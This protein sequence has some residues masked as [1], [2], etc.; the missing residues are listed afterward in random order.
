MPLQQRIGA[1]SVLD[2]F[3]ESAQRHSQRTALTMVMT[4]QD[5]EQPR[6]VNYRE[7]LGLIRRSANL[8]HSLAGPRP[9]VAY[10]LPSLIETHVTLWGAQ[11]AGF[12]V[13]INYLLQVQHIADLIRVSG[14]SVLVALGPHPQLAIWDKAL[15]IKA[16]LPHLQLVCVAP[17]STPAT[18]AALD[19]HTLLMQQADDHLVFGEAGRDDDVAAYFHTGGTT[20]VPKLVEHS[21]R[22]QIAAAFGGTALLHSNE[23]H[24]SFNGNP[25]FHV[26]GIILGSLSPFMAGAEVVVL[27][28]LGF[29]NPVIVR[30]YWKLVQKYRATRIGGV[31]TAIGALCDVAVD[32]ADLSS[33]QLGVCGAASIPMSVVQRFE[34]HTGHPLHEALGMTETAGL[35]CVDPAFGDRVLGSVGFRLP[36]TQVVIRRLNPDGSLGGVCAPEEIGVLTVA[37]PTVSRGYLDPEQSKG[38]FVDGLLNT[39]DLAYASADGRIHIA[40]RTKDLIIRSGHN[41]D[42]LM[43]EEAMSKHPAVTMAAAVSQP[44]VYAGELPVCYLSL[45][46]PGAA[47]QAQLHDWA[48]HH[49][50]ERPAWPK[51]FYLVPSIPVTAVGKI[52]KPQLRAD[53][54][55]RLVLRIVEESLGLNQL[56]VAAHE[57][58]KRGMTV[59]VTLARTQANLAAKIEQA[60]ASYLFESVVVVE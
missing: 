18:D 38:V 53:A 6:R 9:G 31:P 55:E 51:H 12:A 43:I 28:P 37:G 59:T 47:T 1:R 50:A 54:T 35:T 30:R 17:A 7:L 15:E 33:V 40:G 24:V 20:G 5:D 58:G 16:L 60:L 52:F 36:Y 48:Q 57:G 56:R 41:I 3:I 23:T 11:A 42:P 22:N 45:R 49:I 19:F 8:F 27:S 21:H 32:G 2:V 25:L 46:E 34:A 10:M 26:A 39:G 13:P 44:D 4:G 29:R 14:A